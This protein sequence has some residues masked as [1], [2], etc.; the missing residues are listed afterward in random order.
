MNESMEERAGN[1]IAGGMGWLS[2]QLREAPRRI[3][4]RWIQRL[5]LDFRVLYKQFLLRI[6]DLEALSIETDMVEYLAQ[7]AGILIFISGIQGLGMILLRVLH[8]APF[9][10]V[11]LY[12]M[13][14]GAEHGIVEKMLLVAGLIVVF[15]WETPFP[16]RRDMMVLGSLPIRPGTI[17]A[18]KLASPEA[19]LGLAVVCLNWATILTWPPMLEGGLRLFAACWLAVIAVAVFLFASLLAIE[20]MGALLLPRQI[21]LR[22]SA[23]G[24]LTAFALFPIGYFLLGQIDSPAAMMAVENRWTVACWPGYWFLALLRQVAGELPPEMSW[25]A[26]RAWEALAF[27]IASASVALVACYRRTLRRIAEQPDLEPARSGRAWRVPFGD[28][29]QTVLV[30]FSLRTLVRSRQHRIALAFT[31]ALVLGLALGMAHDW[32]EA[33]GPRPVDEGFLISTL[34]MMALAVGGMRGVFALP[35]AHKANWMLRMTQ[36]RPTDR[37]LAATRRILLLLAVVPV[38]LSAVLFSLGYRPWSMAAAHLL[39]LAIFGLLAIE[40]SLIG[41][42]KVPFTCSFL[43]GKVNVQYVFWGFVLVAV[44]IVAFAKGCEQP[45]LKSTANFAVLTMLVIGAMV[46]L[47]LWNRTRERE[48]ELYFEEKPEQQLITLGL[49]VNPRMRK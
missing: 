24:Q 42:A 5:P 10:P 4:G 15:L 2:R 9:T 32:L 35:I 22:L 46:A 28:R 27:S 12:R 23:L 8:P 39:L 11:E 19:V 43:P 40:V 25:L 18:A 16:D 38:W 45:A 49:M 29:L 7:F 31:W 41:F 21:F 13:S 26:W 14:W 20:G 47:R 33:H 34:L 37:Y 3:F 36:L 48:A 44:L 17:L 6:L 30:S 1:A